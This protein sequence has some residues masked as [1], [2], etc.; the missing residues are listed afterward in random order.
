MIHLT[1]S[2][3]VWFI[4]A[5]LFFVSFR[6]KASKKFYFSTII[7]AIW[8]NM[9]KFEKE[10][11]RDKNVRER[12]QTGLSG[13]GHVRRSIFVKTLGSAD[14][15]V[16]VEAESVSR[17]TGKACVCHEHTRRTWDFLWKSSGEKSMPDKHRDISRGRRPFDIRGVFA[18]AKERYRKSN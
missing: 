1:L 11:S 17:A 5:S 14:V 4:T 2:I 12:S 15:N 16:F 18:F 10:Y 9:K 3:Q 6:N 13:L 7:T 8:N